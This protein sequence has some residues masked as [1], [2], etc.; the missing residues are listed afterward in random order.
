MNVVAKVFNLQ[1]EK[2]LKSFE[3]ECEVIRNIRHRNLIKII[4]SCS[5]VDFKALVLEFMLNGSLEKWLYSREYFFG[6][7]RKVEYNDRRCICIGISPSW[8]HITYSPLRFETE[9][10]C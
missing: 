4:S 8:L 9:F 7:I 5:S 2:A 10:D 6:Y 1:A 3:T